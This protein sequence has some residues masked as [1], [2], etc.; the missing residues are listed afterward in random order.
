M[1]EQTHFCK[2]TSRHSFVIALKPMKELKGKCAE[3]EKT[4]KKNIYPCVCTCIWVW[5]W[6]SV[7]VWMLDQARWWSGWL[8]LAELISQFP[9]WGELNA[10]RLSCC[11]PDQAG[12]FLM[13]QA[14]R[15][16]S[17]WRGC[18]THE[19]ESPIRMLGSK[20][21]TGR[22]REGEGVKRGKDGAEEGG[23]PAVRGLSDRSR[24]VAE[25][26]NSSKGLWVTRDERHISAYT[27]VAA[28]SPVWLVSVIWQAYKDQSCSTQGLFTSQEYQQNNAYWS[29]FTTSEYL[30]TWTE[31]QSAFSVFVTQIPPRF[32]QFWF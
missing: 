7:Y 18:L 17:H 28:N 26:Q 9:G 13:R 12:C 8:V 23:L 11:F 1:I 30:I 16:L 31:P 10:N 6:G 25:Q 22:D 21:K 29:T 24:K 32:T 14:D 27:A 5:V 4:E 15:E 3:P 19:N 20:R 2:F